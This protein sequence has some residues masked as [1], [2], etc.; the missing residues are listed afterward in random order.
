MQVVIKEMVEI[1]VCY[2]H[3]MSRLKTV[4]SFSSGGAGGGGGGGGCFNCGKDGHKSFECP[5]PKKAGGGGRS[6][7]GGAGGAGGQRSSK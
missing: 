2:L 3:V 4:T 7:G 5:E 6:F 1:A